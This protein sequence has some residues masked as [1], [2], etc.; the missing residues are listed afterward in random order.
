MDRTVIYFENEDKNCRYN[1]QVLQKIRHLYPDA[2]IIMISA[3]IFSSSGCMI[4]PDCRECSDIYM[5]VGTDLILTLPVA[6]TL[7]GYGQ[8]E[9][10]SAALVQRLRVSEH[11]MVPC[12]PPEGQSLKECE[13]SLR[14]Y[15]MLMIQEK[16]DYR[17]RLSEY[18]DNH[19]SF[20][21][22]Q[23]HA[24]CDVV[25]GAKIVLSS[26]ENQAAL[27]LLVALLQLYYIAHVEFILA[28]EA[29]PAPEAVLAS[30]QECSFTAPKNPIRFNEA[31]AWA[32]KDVLAEC[33]PEALIDI[34][35]STT[36][37]VATIMQQKDYIQSV[38]SLE[39]I[40]ELLQSDQSL[41]RI[42]LFLLKSILG[43]KKIYMQ[44]CGL[45]EYVPYSYIAARNPEK[46]TMIKHLVDNSWVPLVSAH[47]PDYTNNNTERDYS[48]LLQ[49]DQKAADLF[50]QIN[51]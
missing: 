41:E 9:F 18:L 48:Y 23:I 12:S 13:E 14:S 8:K 51:N 2:F 35:G 49:I 25:P 38:N 1:A 44:I 10:A 47:E 30:G 34:S 11:I 50:D 6:S 5:K 4:M 27:W 15:A 40:I 7:G 43:I 42:R 29:I 26:S 22:A 17:A 16:T 45:H 20:R 3:G 37:M 19:M 46:D 36:S 39:Q 33:S 24:I 21:E 32:I 28:P 31:A